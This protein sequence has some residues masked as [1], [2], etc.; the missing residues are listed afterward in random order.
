MKSISELVRHAPLR[1]DVNATSRSPRPAPPPPVSPTSKNLRLSSYSWVWSPECIA[2]VCSFFPPIFVLVFTN[3][4]RHRNFPPTRGPDILRINDLTL[5]ARFEDGT[6]WAMPAAQPVKLSIS[7]AHDVRTSGELD[8][9]SHTL[10]Y[11]S[12]VNTLTESSDGGTFGSLEALTESVFKRCFQAHPQ[13]QSL[14][15]KVTKPKALLRG[16][17]VSLHVS[18]SRRSQSDALASFSFEDME[19]PI[20]IGVNPEERTTKQTVRMNLTLLGRA[21]SVPVDY[22]SLAKGIHE[23]SWLSVTSRGRFLC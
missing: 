22:R 8:E 5:N 19:F 23:V 4:G 7:V 10:N 15:V 9:L 11:F 20:L 1:P 13:I 14:S 21:S 12:V 18:R 3:T 6:Q 17:S 2:E 16:K